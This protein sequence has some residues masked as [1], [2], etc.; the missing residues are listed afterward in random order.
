MIELSRGYSIS[1]LMAY[2]A[3]ACQSGHMALWCDF[4]DTMFA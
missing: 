2:L 3:S 1:V 4:V